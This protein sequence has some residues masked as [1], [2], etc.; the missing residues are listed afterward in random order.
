MRRFRALFV[1]PSELEAWVRG[2]EATGAADKQSAGGR[3]STLVGWNSSLAN[4]YKGIPTSNVPLTAS[5]ESAECAPRPP[6]VSDPDILYR[7]L[8]VEVLNYGIQLSYTIFGQFGGFCSPPRQPQPRATA[9]VRRRLAPRRVL[10]ATDGHRLAKGRGRV[11]EVLAGPPVYLSVFDVC[12][13]STCS[14]LR[15]QLP[16][17]VST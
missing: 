2:D 14:A 10:L 12:S 7:S 17:S 16:V 9:P 11:M 8:S 15:R 4:L 5:A 6:Q 3:P 13:F 1:G